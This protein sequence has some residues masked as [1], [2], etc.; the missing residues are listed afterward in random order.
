MKKIL[1]IEDDK[2]LSD[3]L[4]ILLDNNGYDSY[5]L[6]DFPQAAR[7]AIEFLA[8]LILLDIILP[9]AN[10]QDIL[11][12]IRKESDVPVIMLTSKNTDVDEIMSMSYGADDYIS[13]PYNPTLLLLRIE[14]LFKHIE[15]KQ[16][17]DTVSYQNLTINLLRSTLEYHGQEIIL[18]KNE[19]TIFIFSYKIREEL[20]QEMN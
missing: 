3:E 7:K 10:G 6:F 18:S 19:I 12:E 8:D 11:R 20:F 15:K 13:K 9:G 5:Q 16:V 2:M 17:S 1:I 4:K 14:T